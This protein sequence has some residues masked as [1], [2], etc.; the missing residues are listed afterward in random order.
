MITMRAKKNPKIDISH[1]SSLYFAIGLN[2]MLLIT[3]NLL[4]YKTY[5]TNNDIAQILEMEEE[6]EDDIPITEQ[7][8]TPPPP[9]PPSAAPEIITIVEDVEEIEETIIESSEINQEEGIEERDVYVN[10]V[11]VVEEEEY[12]EVP[13][14]VIEKV[15]VFPGCKG[16][17]NMQLKQCFQEKMNAHLAKHFQYPETAM[18]L[19]IHGRVYVMFVIDSKGHVANIRTRGPDKM[20]EKEAARIIGLLPKMIP[21]KQRG[22][23]VNVPYSIP[24]N[25]KI[26]N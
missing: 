1:N 9:P 26:L 19:G 6:I 22:R 24:I 7:I 2:I 18:E 10:D 23:S 4:N 15:P 17:T 5:D 21:G 13:F 8:K 11:D 25:F 14:A 16:T 3:Y 20:L 12:I